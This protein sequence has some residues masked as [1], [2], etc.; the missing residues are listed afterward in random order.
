MNERPI[1]TLNTGAAND[2]A[3]G[4][5]ADADFDPTT[6]GTGSTHPHPAQSHQPPRDKL[7]LLGMFAVGFGLISVFAWS[8]L[9]VPLALVLGVTALFMG[10]IGWGVSAILLSVIGTLTSPMLLMMIG[11]GAMI[12]FFGMPAPMPIPGGIGI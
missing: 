9:F 6:G 11:M 8:I 12:T 2:G 1:A 4:N 10:Q 3:G 7:P 5:T